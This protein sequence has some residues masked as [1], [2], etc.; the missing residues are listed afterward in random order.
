M[1][2]WSKELM[3]EFIWRLRF[4]I[5]NAAPTLRYLKYIEIW[6]THHTPWLGY[7]LVESQSSSGLT[8]NKGWSGTKAQ[9]VEEP[10]MFKNLLGRK[11]RPGSSQG[12]LTANLK[13]VNRPPNCGCRAQQTSRDTLWSRM[14]SLIPGDAFCENTWED[15]GSVSVIPGCAACGADRFCR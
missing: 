1:V 15:A 3:Y 13:S 9:A 5:L 12:F 11:T 2:D 6:P 4:R 14:S 8:R 10:H 7:Q